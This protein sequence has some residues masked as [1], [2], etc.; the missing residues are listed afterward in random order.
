L[1]QFKAVTGQNS[2][3]KF[4]RPGITTV[5]FDMGGTLAGLNPTYEAVYHRVFQK[6]GYELPLGEVERAISYSWGLVA[7]QDETAEYTNTLE[8]TRT[9]QREVEERVM[10]RLNIRPAVREEVFW[11]IIQAFEDPA[12]YRLYP[13]VIPTLE[14]LKQA[15]YRLAIISNWSWHLPELAEALSLTPYFEQIYTSARVGFAKPHPAIFK[16]ALAGLN[17]TPEET[18]HIGD[19]YRADVQGASRVGIRALWLRRPGEMPLYEADL[20]EQKDPGP[21]E[22]IRTLSEV[23]TYLDRQA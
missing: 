6:A 11:Q 5:F 17:R 3:V 2:P 18:I 13:E 21:V 22:S 9:W 23:V 4:A 19:S 15:N 12:T 20:A 16:S 1:S 8:G 14:A 7:E 10:E